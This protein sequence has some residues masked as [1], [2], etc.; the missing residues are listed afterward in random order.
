MA[1]PAESLHWYDRLGRPSYTQKAKD[2]TD[3]P[4]TL[5][6]ARKLNLLPSVTTVCRVAAAP[7]LE[8]YKQNQLLMAALT[9]PR[10]P[11][12][13][14]ADWIERVW[15]DSREHAKEAAELGTSIHAE[16]EGFYAEAISPEKHPV[17]VQ[18]VVDLLAATVPG[19]RWDAERTFASPLGYAGKTDLS[20]PGIVLDFKTKPFDAESDLTKLAW[21]E[22]A[23]QIVAYAQ[24]LYPSE[25]CV[26]GN[27]FVSTTVA[28]LTHLHIWSEDDLDR[29]YRKFMAL[30]EYWKADRGYDPTFTSK[31]IDAMQAAEMG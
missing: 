2:G 8:R 22:M 7:G 21:P 27:V 19:V 24:G 26:C 25:D 9:L 4:T 20:A 11:M 17:Q 29:A 28:G 1:H 13:P 10:M 15:A 6:D 5:R 31:D 12:E 18:G 14:E 3:R 23:M 30:L 16:L